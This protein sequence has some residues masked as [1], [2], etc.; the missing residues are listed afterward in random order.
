MSGAPVEAI[1]P[2]RPAV[3]R[4]APPVDSCHHAVTHEPP[5]IMQSVHAPRFVGPPPS[6][7]SKITRL[8]THGTELL[9]DVAHA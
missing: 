8:R 3:V 7:G 6:L 2:S 1:R 4:R 5:V 9:G